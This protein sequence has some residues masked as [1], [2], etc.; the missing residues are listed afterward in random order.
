[1]MVS[2]NKLRSGFDN[3]GSV[4]GTFYP[5]VA[6]PHDQTLHYNNPQ[7]S[8]NNNNYTIQSNVDNNYN[9]QVNCSNRQQNMQMRSQNDQCS[10]KLLYIIINVLM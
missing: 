9:H 3:V 2:C 10:R 8:K 1:M 6:S 4:T 5:P 7:S